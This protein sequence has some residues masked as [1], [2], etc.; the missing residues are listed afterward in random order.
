MIKFDIN[1]FKRIPAAC[2]NER[3]DALIGLN[4]ARNLALREG[5]QLGRW[6]LVFDG[7]CFFTL[8]AWKNIV[9]VCS[10]KAEF[11]YVIV[12]MIRIVLGQNG[13]PC[14]V[15]FRSFSVMTARKNLMR[16]FGMAR[17]VRWIYY[18]DWV[19]RVYGIAGIAV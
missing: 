16:T 5:K 10:K 15:Y 7:S 8:S 3:H 12:P 17:T 14:E 19:F 9:Q 2:F 1:K 4:E 6:I 13:I 18:S 11:K